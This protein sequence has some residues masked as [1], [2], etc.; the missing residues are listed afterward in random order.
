VVAVLALAAIACTKLG[1]DPFPGGDAGAADAGAADAG[2][3]D[4]RPDAGALADAGGH[5]GAPIR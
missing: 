4:A 5:D 3:V 1:D 2:A